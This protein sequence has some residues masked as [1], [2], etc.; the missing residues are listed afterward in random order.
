M[1]IVMMR[2]NTSAAIATK[3]V[4][5]A[6]HRSGCSLRQLH[7]KIGLIVLTTLALMAPVFDMMSVEYQLALVTLPI[8]L[9]G[10]VHGGLDPWVGRLVVQNLAGQSTQWLFFFLYLVTML[11]VVALWVW[12]PLAA[13]AGFLAISILHFGEQDAASFGLRHDGLTV[14]VFGAV[15]VLG[16][17]AAH[18]AE[19]ALVFSWLIAIEPAELAVFLAWLVKP[20]FA[21]WLV[22]A[23]MW[24]SRLFIVQGHDKRFSLV[25]LGVLTVAVVVLPP[26]IAF[27]AYF[28]LLHSF[29]HIFDMAV[30]ASGPWRLWSPRQWALRLWPATLGA[31]ALCLAGGFMLSG[32]D[33]GDR[34]DRNVLA[35]IVFCGLAALTFPHVLLHALF[36]NI[37][38]HSPALT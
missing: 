24:V 34:I 11:L 3:N 25:A 16:P 7:L 37:P 29:G 2:V 17:I 31:L 9:L 12:A 10:V 35:Q 15:P 14:L 13:L 8:A 33:I 5:V 23:G 21:I 30:N 26:L 20:L 22:G 36:R 28:C 19:V 18:P 6:S 4:A 1:I 27:S 38:Q 32:L